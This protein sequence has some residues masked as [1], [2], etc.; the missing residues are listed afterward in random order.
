MIIIPRR[1]P[2]A[3]KTDVNIISHHPDKSLLP[4][5]LNI[6]YIEE[7]RYHHPT[8]F[9]IGPYK[10]KFLFYV[11]RNLP[12]NQPSDEI[13][14]IHNANLYITTHFITS[15]VPVRGIPHPYN[16]RIDNKHEAKNTK[17]VSEVS[18]HPKYTQ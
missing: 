7:F 6:Y 5:R 1:K 17:A 15:E 12:L 13:L 3:L 4:N 9:G 14:L 2:K 8:W 10:E 11:K 16:L 18:N